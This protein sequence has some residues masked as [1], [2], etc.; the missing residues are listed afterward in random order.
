MRILHTEASSGWGGQEI[1]ILTE[2]QVF[3]RHGHELLVAADVDSQ[4]V[5]NATAYGIKAFPI[6]LKKKRFSDFF[7]LRKLIHQQKPDRKSVV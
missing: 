3:A 1:R 7:A 2:S 4:I 5:Q 6:R